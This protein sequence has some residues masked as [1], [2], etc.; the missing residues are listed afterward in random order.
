MV[1]PGLYPS[2]RK[3]IGIEE[4]EDTAA[5]ELFI[6]MEECYVREESGA[7]AVLSRVSSVP[8]RNFVVS[9]GISGEFSGNPEQLMQDGIKRLHQKK[10]RRRL[11]GLAAELHGLEHD[12]VARGREDRLD[13]LLTEKMYIDAEL[14]RLKEDKV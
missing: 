10:L 12:P 5:R 4:I 9:K 6:A 14:R 2:F 8:L 3:A 7:D 13:E 1:N 11:S